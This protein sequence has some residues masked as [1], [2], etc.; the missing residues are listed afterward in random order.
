M[1]FLEFEGKDPEDA[2]CKRQHI[3]TSPEE[4]KSRCL[5]GLVGPVW[6]LGGKS[7]NSRRLNQQSAPIIATF[8]KKQKK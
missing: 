3:S 7:Q 4:W 1:D 2:I 5:I 8:T 6:F